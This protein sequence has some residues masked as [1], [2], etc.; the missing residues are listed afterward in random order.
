MLGD[1][2]GADGI[3]VKALGQDVGIEAAIGFLGVMI[4][5]MEQ[6]RR[7]KNETQGRTVTEPLGRCG[8]AGLVLNVDDTGSSALVSAAEA[9]SRQG[10]DS[11][12]TL[13]GQ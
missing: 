1:E 7:H 9:A 12:E 4:R 5:G 8:D 6:S 10:M 3:D 13:T 11:L 2:C